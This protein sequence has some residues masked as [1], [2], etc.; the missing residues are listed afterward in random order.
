MSNSATTTAT[1]ELPAE[2]PWHRR[3]KLW[4]RET[5]IRRLLAEGYSLAQ[6]I[7]RLG[8]RVSRP[9][10]WRWL[11]RAEKARDADALSALDLFGFVPP[12]SRTSK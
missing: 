9:T 6:I 2:R 10:L 12:T 8:L 3:S 5:E 1:P 7:R 4:S 11:Q